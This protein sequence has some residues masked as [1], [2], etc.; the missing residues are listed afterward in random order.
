M[1]KER[2]GFVILL[3]ISVI[4]LIVMVLKMIFVEQAIDPSNQWL[5]ATHNGLN[6]FFISVALILIL[7]N[8][9]KNIPLWI[10]SCL[11]IL[12]PFVRAWIIDFYVFVSYVSLSKIILNLVQIGN[13]LPAFYYLIFFKRVSFF[14]KL[15][16]V[17]HAGLT[18][19]LATFT[20]LYINFDWQFLTVFGQYMINTVQII[21]SLS[22]ISLLV[23]NFDYTLA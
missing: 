23:F 21:I 11:I 8:N 6:I 5:I 19:V 13:L 9:L 17:L 3:S 20:L 7:S 12:F 16:T 15:S 4:N 14:G 1:K 2:L 18:I 22:L 10:L